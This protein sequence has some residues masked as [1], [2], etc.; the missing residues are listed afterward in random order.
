[1]SRRYLGETFDIHGGG[2][3]LIFPH[4]ENERA[5]SRCGTDGDFARYWMHNGYLMVHGDKMAKSVGN[6]LT[7]HE[8]LEHAPGEAVRFAMLSAH[9]HGPLD[10]T[11]EGLNQARAALDR[12]YTALD[13]AADVTADA[14]AGPPIAVRAALLDDL[15]TPQAIAG[16]HETAS[17]LNKATDAAERAR[18]KGQLLA[19]GH[20]LGLL[21][22]DPAAWFRWTPAA[23]GGPSEEEI[24][25]LIEQRRE[26]RRNKDFAT[27]DAIRDD[28]AA[29]GVTLQDTPEGTTWRRG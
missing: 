6:I 11:E 28:L 27:A 2:Q 3:D 7:V 21:E 18:L 9:Y 5:Q 1:M 16:L 29:R 25:R 12:L 22:Q 23:G 24:E 14:D 4:H 10:W 19:G 26:A 20:L 13:R 8:L 17:A 15:N